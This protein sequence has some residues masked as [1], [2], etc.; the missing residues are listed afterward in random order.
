[1]TPPWPPTW[2]KPRPAPTLERRLPEPDPR[3]WQAGLGEVLRIL[4]DDDGRIDVEHVSG[5]IVENAGHLYQ[6][7]AGDWAVMGQARDDRGFIA[8]C[9]PG[10]ATRAA[11]VAKARQLAVEGWL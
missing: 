8:L 6:S 3:A 9:V 2:L 1:M 7:P 11:A 4:V 10:I 5:R